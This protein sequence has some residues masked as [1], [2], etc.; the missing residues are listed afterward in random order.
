ML[1]T[2]VTRARKVR[3]QITHSP[4]TTL[5]TFTDHSRAHSS[6]VVTTGRRASPTRR[7]LAFRTL[8]RRG[9]GTVARR[10]LG[11]HAVGHLCFTWVSQAKSAHTHTHTV[12]G[13][14]KQKARESKKTCRRGG[15][16]L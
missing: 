3:F 7:T 9:G 15:K 2:A 12:G 11:G 13:L 8:F 4:T 14:V 1:Q 10:D 5:H 16:K 6:V